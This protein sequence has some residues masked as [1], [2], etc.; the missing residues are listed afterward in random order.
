MTPQL[1]KNTPLEERLL[2]LSEVVG[3]CWEWQGP[4]SWNGYG[5]ITGNVSRTAHR[6]AYECWV[7]PVPTGLDVHHECHNR[8]CINP[9]HLRAVTR[10]E[11][12]RDPVTRQR[13][14]EAQRKTHCPQG[15]PYTP[16]NTRI[17]KQGWQRCLICLRA[18]W[19][20]ENARRKG[21]AG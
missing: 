11:N 8:L 5:L 6:V 12:M 16:E 10:S 9:R 3:D 18:K 7:G 1:L 4:K 15:H 19:K 17:S 20:R 21:M 13:Q 2:W 14:S